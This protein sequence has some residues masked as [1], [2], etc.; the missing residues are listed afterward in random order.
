MPLHRAVATLLLCGVCLLGCSPQFN[1]REVQPPGT[2]LHALM[3]CKPDEAVRVVPLDG[4][5]AEM[6]LLGCDAGGATFVIGWAAVPGAQLGAA[7]GEWQDSTLMRVGIRAGPDAPA[8][9]AFLPAGSLALPQSVRLRALGHA[10]DGSALAVQAAW[11][12]DA[13]SSQ[14]MFAAVYRDPDS[15]EAIESFFSGLRVR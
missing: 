3:P 15:A 2:R 14:A 11:F 4:R 13:G 9:H 10:P 1:W 6:H 8:G 12:A 7:L 5:Q